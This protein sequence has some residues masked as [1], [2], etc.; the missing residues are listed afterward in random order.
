MCEVCKSGTFDLSQMVSDPI[1]RVFVGPCC[2][3]PAGEPEYGVALTSK[4]GFVAYARYGGLEV[5]L[6]K[7]PAELSAFVNGRPG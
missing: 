2:A 5:T 6:R 1:Q 3:V 7:N 4:A